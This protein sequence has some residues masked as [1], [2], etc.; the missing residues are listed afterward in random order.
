MEPK[1]A[2]G[3][4][5][6]LMFLAVAA[7]VVAFANMGFPVMVVASIGMVVLLVYGY[8]LYKRYNVEVVPESDICLFADADDLRILCRIYGLDCSGDEQVI[9]DRLAEFARKNRSRAFTWVAPKAVLSL[10]SAFEVSTKPVQ[11]QEH[12]PAKPHLTGG[13]SRSEARLTAIRSCPICDAKVSGKD[14]VCRECGADL[15]FY[16]VFQ[17]SK[18]GRRLVTE[19]SREMRRKL[20]YEVPS[21]GGKT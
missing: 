7:L 13:Q 20:R 2:W 4:F 18:V 5:S 16:T 21:L 17:E 3:A 9:R 10:G 6:L 14:R 8:V 1:Q 12:A 19:K 11:E 15:E